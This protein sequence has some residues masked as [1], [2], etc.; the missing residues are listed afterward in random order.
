MP[1]PLDK[2]RYAIDPETSPLV[3]RIFEMAADGE[4]AHA[5]AQTLTLEKVPS[6][7]DT[8]NGTYTGIE[9][10]QSGIYRMLKNKVYIG[11]MV[12]GRQIKPSFKSKKTI[13]THESEWVVIPDMH[14]PLIELETFELVQRRLG[15]KKRK[16]MHKAENIFIGIAKCYDCGANLTLAKNSQSG[17]LA[18]S[19][20][21]HRNFSKENK[22]TMHYINYDFLSKLVLNAIRSNIAVVNSNQHRMEEF[23]REA[24]SKNKK[25]VVSTDESVLIKLTGR[26]AELDKIIEKLFEGIVLSDIPLERFKEMSAKYENERIDVVSRIAKIQTTLAQRTDVEANYQ[27]FFEMMMKYKGEDSLSSTMLNELIDRIEVHE[28][29]GTRNQRQQ[30]VDIHYRFID[31]GLASPEN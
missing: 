1:D 12:Y 13:L 29:T 7:H 28:A 9:W 16:T 15:V 22:C 20:Y 8:K 18:I 21:K 30:Q 2:R 24:M 4:N 10:K 6:P 19:C 14:E 23:I 5:I 17:I 11:C 25:T 27:Q 3:K 31:E 26:K